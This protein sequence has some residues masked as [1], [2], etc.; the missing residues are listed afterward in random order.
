MV[1]KVVRMVQIN[2]LTAAAVRDAKKM[3]RVTNE[4]LSEATGIPLT[5][6]KRQINGHRSFR[7]DHLVLI[8]EALDVPLETLIPT[9]AALHSSAA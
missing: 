8:A 7:L 1:L 3:A 9:S 4:E 5:T 2:E 6:L